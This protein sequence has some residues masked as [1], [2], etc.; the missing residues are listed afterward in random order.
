V[1][2]IDRELLELADRITLAPWTFEPES[3]AALRALGF[4]DRGLFDACVA[5][6]TAGVRSRIDVCL[7]ALGR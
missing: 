3:Y 5:A 2:V 6:T 1:D 7:I 4:D